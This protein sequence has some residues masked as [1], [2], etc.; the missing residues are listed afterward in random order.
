MEGGRV[1]T[2]EDNGGFRKTGR[3][4]AAAGGGGPERGWGRGRGLATVRG[5]GNGRCGWFRRGSER[6]SVGGKMDV[7]VCHTWA[8]GL[9]WGRHG[10]NLLG[11]FVVQT[12]LLN[13]HRYICLRDSSPFG[14]LPPQRS[15]LGSWVRWEP[16]KAVGKMYYTQSP[17]EE[18][19][20]SP[21]G[22]SPNKLC[23]RWDTK[24]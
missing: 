24:F 14:S 12:R 18:C 15:E 23:E 8:G 21:S 20:I 4:R 11:I 16:C 2:S 17:R 9:A 1:G 22:I 19:H 10:R 6:E 13:S 3:G 5:G 7:G